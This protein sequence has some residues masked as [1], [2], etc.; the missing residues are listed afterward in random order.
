[1]A[2]ELV[3]ESAAQAFECDLEW[4]V[5]ERL[6]LAAVVADDMVVVLPA[7]E[8]GLVAGNAAEV[9]TL[10][11]PEP[12]EL[13]ERPIDARKP[14]RRSGGAKTVKDLGG[15]QAALLAREMVDDG[16]ARLASAADRRGGALD[17]SV[18]LGFGG[19][20]HAR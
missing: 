6:D 20:R 1:V 12:E 18:E 8:E 4:A 14:C 2:L 11:E 10:D 17:P 9:H 5:R 16:Q 3:P 19:G 15:A 13:V 7:R